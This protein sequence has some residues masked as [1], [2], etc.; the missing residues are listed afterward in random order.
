MF[1]RFAN[2]ARLGCRRPSIAWRPA[3]TVLLAEVGVWSK[4]MVYMFGLL[5]GAFLRSSF[6]FI[7]RFGLDIELQ[8]S[9]FSWGVSIDCGSQDR[10]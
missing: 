3:R 5:L 1:R 6:E 8:L 7:V 9:S 4:Y 2:L 10:Q